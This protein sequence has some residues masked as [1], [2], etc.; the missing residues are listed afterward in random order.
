[1]CVPSRL[2]SL[3]RLEIPESIREN[4]MLLIRV[5]RVGKLGAQPE[6]FCNTVE[7]FCE[8]GLSLECETHIAIMDAN[9]LPPCS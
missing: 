6:C 2:G 9:V 5:F 7:T 4:A 8:N 1:M 3:E